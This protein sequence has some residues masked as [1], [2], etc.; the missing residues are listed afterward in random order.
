VALAAAVVL[1]GLRATPVCAWN[2]ATHRAIT[3]LAVDALPSGPLKHELS[4]HLG[5]LEYRSVEPDKLRELYGK[6][7]GRRHYIDLELYGA[8]PFAVL[9]PVQAVMV[10]R[11]GIR[12]FDRA[13]TLPWTIEQV[14]GQL[15]QAWR[16]ANCT[17][18]IVLAGHLSHYIGDASQ[19]LHTTLY[20]EGYAGDDHMHERLEEAVDSE[21]GELESDARPRV[22]IAKLD[23]VW[24]TLIAELR[25]S[26]ALL[27]DLVAA[28]RAAR[29]S[30]SGSA[31]FDVALIR[32]E[33]TLIVNQLA[34]AASVLAS[35]WMLEW[36]QAGKPSSCA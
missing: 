36:T 19:P 31:Q 28:D 8:S 25:E 10:E 4:L 2:S 3:F 5:E 16:N 14:A 17:E 26:H 24:P 29:A 32:R 13:G 12:K 7:E 9:T 33:R 27:P 34:D 6:V 30:T 11:F 15:E 23:S 20:Y 1:V 35:L 21:I 18:V 22:R